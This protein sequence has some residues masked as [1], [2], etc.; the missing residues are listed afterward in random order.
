[1]G[2]GSV[3]AD[4]P[5]SRGSN[6]SENVVDDLIETML[7]GTA[8]AVGW[9]AWWGVRFPFAST[10]IVIA[11]S[12]SVLAGWRLG[13]V[14]AV[15]YAIG[16]GLWWYL[17]RE[18]FHR[19]VWQPIQ[20]SWLTWWR[21]KRS[22]EHVS[23]L[24]G[25]TARLGERTLVPRLQWVNIGATC[26]VLAVR[27]VTGQCVAVVQGDPQFSWRRRADR[28]PSGAPRL[29]QRI[30]ALLPVRDA[31][32]GHDPHRQH[33]AGCPDVYPLQSRNQGSLAQPRG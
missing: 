21:Y 20:Q 8:K 29:G 11:L 16:Y 25:L 27:I 12:A 5:K 4:Q 10:P 19:V 13:V 31:L 32:A 14:V 7:V 26:D 1:M 17:D 22:W 2:R 15:V 33:V 9:L 23:T 28:Y 18:S 24:H 6:N 3:V 30:A